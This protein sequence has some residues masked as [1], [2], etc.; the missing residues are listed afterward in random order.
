[1]MTSTK[2]LLGTID[3]VA[4]LLAT[5]LY[6]GN[7]ARNPIWNIASTVKTITHMQVL[8]EYCYT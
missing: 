6:Q 1:M 2:P 4:S 7:P 5:T 8:L 3:S